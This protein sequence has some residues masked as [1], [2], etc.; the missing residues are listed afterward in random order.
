M[1]DVATVTVLR[2]QPHCLLNKDFQMSEFAYA[3]M[4]ATLPI[5]WTIEDA[6][7]PEFWSGVAHRLQKDQLSGGHDRAGAIVEL[8]TVDHR[9]YAE[10]YVLAVRDQTLTVKLIREPVVLQ[11]DE[12]D[13]SGF[14]T[15]WNVGARG[16]SIIR[17]SDKQIVNDASKFPL[18]EDAIDWIEKT[19]NP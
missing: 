16:W 7:K 2:D 11:S 4:C 9:F 8:R 12:E 10:V 5:G 14:E 15:R 13:L 18:K 19:I 6:L 3:R 1:K 17:K